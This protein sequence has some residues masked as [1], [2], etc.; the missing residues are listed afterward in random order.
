MKIIFLLIAVLAPLSNAL[1][2]GSGS[3]SQGHAASESIEMTEMDKNS[4]GKPVLRPIEEPDGK[5]SGDPARNSDTLL[6][7]RKMPVFG[8]IRRP[9][10]HKFRGFRRVK[11]MRPHPLVENTSIAAKWAMGK[12]KTRLDLMDDYFK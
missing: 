6:G 8:H 1:P 5:H 9:Q 10:H 11:W 12:S 2:Q 3:G 7:G 4:V